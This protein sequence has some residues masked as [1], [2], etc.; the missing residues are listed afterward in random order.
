MESIILPPCC[1]KPEC[2]GC[3]QPVSFPLAREIAFNISQAEAREVRLARGICPFYSNGQANYFTGDW[4]MK[5][6]LTC[7]VPLACEV[8]PI[9]S[10]AEACGM[11]LP[12]E[13]RPCF[14]GRPF[15]MFRVIRVFR[16]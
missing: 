14:T 8:A 10:R 12:R 4:P 16:G 2:P 6:A 9:T 1:S 13:T 15:K 3:F 7:E 11:R 5:S